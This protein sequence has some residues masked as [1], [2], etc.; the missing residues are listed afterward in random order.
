MPTR[1]A[2][3]RRRCLAATNGRR[4]QA[5]PLRIDTIYDPARARLKVVPARPAPATTA[6]LLKF[7][8]AYLEA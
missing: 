4:D 2:V 1:R 3:R 5:D 6:S 8:N 7:I